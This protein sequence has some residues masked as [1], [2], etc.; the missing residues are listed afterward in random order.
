MTPVLSVRGLEKLC[1]NNVAEIKF[2]RRREK[3]KFPPTRRIFCTRHQLLLNSTFG[4]EVLK[5]K[6]PTKS[7]P[8][9]ASRYGLVTVWDILMQDWRNIPADSCAVI[10][11][12][13]PDPKNKFKGFM[14]YFDRYIRPMTPAQKRKFMD[15]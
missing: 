6:R 7:P 1:D 2:V 3:Q 8:Y 11:A 10:Q 12:I 9:I 4:I 15:I 14:T 5:F 13:P